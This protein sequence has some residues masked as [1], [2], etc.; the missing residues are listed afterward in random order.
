MS[1]CFGRTQAKKILKFKLQTKLKEI[2][3]DY[4][5]VSCTSSD[6][7]NNTCK[8]SKKTLAKIVGGV[9]FTR[10]PVSIYFG[11]S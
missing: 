8:V 7:D 3:E 10:Y 4:R 9:V 11:R 2:F 5:K 6:P 1:I